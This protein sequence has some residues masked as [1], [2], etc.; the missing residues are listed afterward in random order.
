[1]LSVVS[2]KPICAEAMPS[3]VPVIVDGFVSAPICLNNMTKRVIA[4]N[5]TVVVWKKRMTDFGKLKTVKIRKPRPCAWC[6]Q[7]LI[8][9]DRAVS[10]CG[11][12][13]GDWQ[14]WRMHPECYEVF[15]SDP[16]S[17]TEGF[18][19]YEGDRPASGPV[20]HG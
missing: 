15:G 16:D 6:S 19:L 8:E 7:K 11:M 3:R 10:Y 13:Q 18:T 20:S 17:V 14:N 4:L 9:G 12:W 1:M 2:A 5:V